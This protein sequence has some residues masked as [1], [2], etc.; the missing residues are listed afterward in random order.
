MTSAMVLFLSIKIG[1]MIAKNKQEITLGLECVRF[2][3]VVFFRIVAKTK[4]FYVSDSFYYPFPLHGLPFRLSRK[5]NHK[6][7]RKISSFS[8]E[9][10]LLQFRLI[11]SIFEPEFN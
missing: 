4:P 9:N 3:D 10:R 6:E 8:I 11:H 1:F 2:I 7:I 5:M